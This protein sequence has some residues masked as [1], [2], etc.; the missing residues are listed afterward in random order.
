MAQVLY[1]QSLC[2]VKPKDQTGKRQL[3]RDQEGLNL[4]AKRLRELREEKG[5]TQE[6]LAFRSGISVSPVSRIETGVINPTVSTMFHIA[7][8]LRVSVSELFSFRLSPLDIA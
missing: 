1:A 5:F 3:I 8:S 7:R 2:H 4:L 6:E